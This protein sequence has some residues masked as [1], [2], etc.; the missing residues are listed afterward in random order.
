VKVVRLGASQYL[1]GICAKLTIGIGE[2]PAMA[3][4]PSVGWEFPDMENLGQPVTVRKGQDLVAP[5]VEERIVLD[6]RSR[7]ARLDQSTIPGLSPSCC[8]I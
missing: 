8:P 3:H 2:V 4:E 5:A 7:D 6:D 1:A